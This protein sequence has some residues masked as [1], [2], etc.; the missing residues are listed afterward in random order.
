DPRHHGPDP[1]QHDRDGRSRAHPRVRRA[2]G[3]RLHAEA[4]PALGPRRSDGGGRGRRRARTL[5]LL[6][7]R[8]AR[9]R[10]FPRREHGRHVPLLPDSAG[11][12]GRRARAH[13]PAR[14]RRGRHPRLPGS[15]AQRRRL[16]A[17]SWLRR[18]RMIP[19]AYNV[20]SLFVR[21]ATTIATA[22]GIGL[23]VFVLAASLMLGAGIKK[24]LV[25]GGRPDYA[26]VLRKG[27][28]TELASSIEVRTVSL[29]L[30]AP[31]VKK[32]NDGAPVGSGELVVVI[33][34]EK[35][36]TDGQVSNVQ[37]RG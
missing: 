15:E 14:A 31:G 4:H 8:R 13:R 34:M 27:S 12:G 22:L 10:P 26:L 35:P 32:A 16:P 7:A 30:A 29:V 33:T 37:V 18:S 25:S 5:A 21:K 17:S 36:G 24:T 28:D 19:I 20:R 23:V 2:S 9:P 11:R 1:R 3:H 6:S